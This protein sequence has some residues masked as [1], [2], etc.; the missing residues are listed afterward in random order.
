LATYTYNGTDYPDA[1]NT[2]VPAGVTLTPHSGDL[3]INTPGAVISGL[4]ITGTVYINAPNVT[5]VNCKVTSN[6]Y[7][8]V[9]VKEG[10]TGTVVQNC[11]IDGTGNGPAGQHGIGGAGTFIGNNIF[12]TKDGINI[13]GSN[14]VIKDNYIHDL[15]TS[16]PAITHFDGIFVDGGFNN[17]L[18]SHN[19]VLGRD[20]SCVFI[21]N[22]FGPM[23]NIV[24]DRN[25][26]LGQND[27]A[28][29]IY[30]I[31]KAGNPAQITNVQV[32][33]N[34]IGKGYW[35]WDSVERTEPVWTNNVDYATGKII[36]TDN[37]L[38]SAPTT[39]PPAPTPTP[40]GAPDISSWSP[41][42]GAVGDGVTNANKLTLKGT[43]A[44]N[45]TVKV[46][47]GS[48]QIG[49]TTADAT[50]SWDYITAVLTDARHVL[51]ATDTV[52]GVT[53][54]A[55]SPLSVTVDTHVPA[56]PVLV[57][58]PIVN[59][60][61]VL[62]SGTAE[63]NSTITVY[64]GKTAV[65]TTTTGANGTWSVTTA[66]LAS[67]AQA[68]TATATDV[69]G[70][71]SAVSQALDPVIGTAPPP[72]PPAAP[73]ITSFSTDSGV[74]GDHITNDN[75]PMLTGTAVANSTVNVFDGTTQI[76]TTTANSS[77]QWHLT[78]PVLSDG[79]HNLTTTDTDS[80]GHNSAPSAAFSD[81]IDTHAPSAP[82]MA[83]YSQGGSAVGNATTLSDLVLKGAAEA[84][85]TI[86]VF[87]SGKQ[88]GATT[89]N[90]SGAWSL[91]TGHLAN[92]SHSFTATAIDVAGN[93]SAA[94]PAKAE[95]VT[96]P[97]AS[98]TPIE[99]KNVYEHWNDTATI[100]G[101][102]DAH[103][104][105]KIYDGTTSLGTVTASA[106]GTWSFTTTQ[107]SDTLHTFKAQ[108]LD[109]TG[110]VVATS[111]GAA[112]VAAS[113]T[114]TLTGTGGDDFLFSSSSQLN[115]TF[116]FASNFGHSTVQGFTVAGSGQDTI[117]FSKTV[118]D[119]FASV[120]SHA[121]QVGQD[122]VIST[123][124]ESLTLTNTKLGTLNSHDFHFA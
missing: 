69:A 62:L 42:T 85:S 84:N 70:N 67:G 53:S 80:S 88:I 61:H 113:N 73:K 27:A 14:T 39:P 15:N 86:D 118:F 101:T 66:P 28:A 9:A 89:T 98:T 93:T 36:S 82:T 83:V 16:D 49:T 102:A 46:Y 26:L 117:Q 43:A 38:S 65:G 45:S 59:T 19:T 100:E 95:T 58:D 8:V 110:H 31:E 52:S 24:V 50:G 99:F 35:Y 79:T 54:A 12:N 104:Q 106:K 121:S 23:D 94:S 22:D 34:V 25:L 30:V 57:S 33:N 55:S 40:P 96:A 4:N 72:T 20:T 6:N 51:T 71:V 3:V 120:L 81:T 124:G 56:A 10:I 11:T 114:S 122:V 60:N 119:S 108:E 75:T 17:V 41:D 2:G 103:S 109:S 29:S 123:G 21:C 92:G 1:T 112:I 64:D 76:G 48:T 13:E 74:V 44:A 90:G 47:D 115:D 63:A 18:I 91:D 87:D 78:T 68:L 107:L 37:V 116:V 5:L 77:G 97:A 7:Y 111:S 32:T 105:I